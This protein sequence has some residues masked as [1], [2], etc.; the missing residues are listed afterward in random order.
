MDLY[1]HFCC[2][3]ALAS[4]L[5][6]VM[7]L[8]APTHQQAYNRQGSPASKC[9]SR[10]KTAYSGRKGPPTEEWFLRL[11]ALKRREVAPPGPTKAFLQPAKT[12]GMSHHLEGDT[13][14]PFPI[15]TFFAS[16]K[17]I[18]KTD[19]G[20]ICMLCTYHKWLKEKRSLRCYWIQPT[21]IRI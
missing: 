6:G 3:L 15:T 17:Y 4:V 18:L 2:K 12:A 10:L 5:F 8:A 19:C 1:F 7:T 21:A 9:S 16:A 14:P 13:H 11:F 20:Q